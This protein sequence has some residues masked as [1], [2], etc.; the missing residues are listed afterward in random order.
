MKYQEF[1]TCSLKCRSNQ[2][3]LE[4]ISLLTKTNDVQILLSGLM[5]CWNCHKIQDLYGRTLLHMAASCG[6]AELIEW[7]LRFKKIDMN[8]KTYENGWT[9][10]HCASFYGQ[11]N[12]LVT[13]IRLGANLF[14]N[15]FDRLT[16]MDHLTLDKWL[17]TKYEPDLSGK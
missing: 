7:L 14:K 8:N 11:I 12:S 5:Q 15:D 3:A 17:E 2:H 13:L 9:A 6:R 1:K 10:A 4:L 16:P